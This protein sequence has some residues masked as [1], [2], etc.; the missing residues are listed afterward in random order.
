MDRAL[1]SSS[2]IDLA[3]PNRIQCAKFLLDFCTVWRIT[4]YGNLQ[5]DAYLFPKEDDAAPGTI[6]EDL[7][8][9]LRAGA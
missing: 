5:R 1:K 6:R 2:N 8:A 4:A 9:L 3:A 7:Q